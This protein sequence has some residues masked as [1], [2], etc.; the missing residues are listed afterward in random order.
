MAACFV[1]THSIMDTPHFLG[2]AVHGARNRN[3]EF[4]RW[5]CWRYNAI[6]IGFPERETA[7]CMW[8]DCGTL[9]ELCNKYELL[10]WGKCGDIGLWCPNP[11]GKCGDLHLAKRVEIGSKSCLRSLDEKIRKR[12]ACENK[13]VYV[14]I[15]QL[16][17]SVREVQHLSNISMN[18]AVEQL[19][20][21]WGA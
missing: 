16:F 20:V 7:G 10:W 5:P 2:D 12:S 21:R 3:G 1:S 15:H 19:A 14:E 11:L 6:V 13:E 18:R 4:S 9:C 8:G 17:F